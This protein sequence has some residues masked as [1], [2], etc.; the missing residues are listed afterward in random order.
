MA[1]PANLPDLYREHV[2]RLAAGYGAALERHGFGAL[3]IHSGSI[4]L[5]SRFDDA[6][7]PYRPCPPFAHWLPL[8]EAEAYLVVQPGRRP[9]V[10]RAYEVGFWDGP[11]PQP[12]DWVWAEID[13]QVIAP[14]AL[15][16]ELPAGRL[17]FVGEDPARAQALGIPREH[18]NPPELVADFNAVRTVKSEYE[19]EC[20]LEAS[21]RGA[22]GHDAIFRM[23]RE[24]PCSE[25]ELH[26]EYLRATDQ[27]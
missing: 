8:R 7:W 11:A 16:G 22:R 3:V 1:A 5:K 10:L 24:R 25:L 14:A 18:V 26:L 17:A 2:Q 27:D 21:R 12:P 19:R 23:F 9:R 15:P 20:L 4:E 13:Q 6:E